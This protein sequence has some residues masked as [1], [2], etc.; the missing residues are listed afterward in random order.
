MNVPNSLRGFS[1]RLTRPPLGTS[2]LIIKN[3]YLT[4]SG[5]LEVHGY[6][7][8]KNKIL[9]QLVASVAG[10]TRCVNILLKPLITF[11]WPH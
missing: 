7:K 8:K 10:C 3:L 4:I 1:I 6:Q 11:E 2:Q 5:W 9:S